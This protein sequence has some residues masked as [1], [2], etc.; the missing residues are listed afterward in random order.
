[1]NVQFKDG[2]R[3]ELVLKDSRENME[4]AQVQTP[5]PSTAETHIWMQEAE[6]WI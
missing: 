5:L 6:V 3:A 2:Q 4:E 1:M